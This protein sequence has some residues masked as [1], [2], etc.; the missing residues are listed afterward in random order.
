MAA[1]TNTWIHNSRSVSDVMLMTFA[2][3][4]RIPVEQAAKACDTT[5]VM[6]VNYY[7]LR[8]E[9][10]EAA[11]SNEVINRPLGGPRVDVEVDE[12]N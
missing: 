10:A 11:M 5:S 4:N 9:I 12:T 6:A 1:T 7:S 8:G 2:W 3:V